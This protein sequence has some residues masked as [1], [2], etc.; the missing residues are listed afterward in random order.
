MGELRQELN[1]T[2]LTCAQVCAIAR[3]GASVTVTE[4]G[5][6]RARAAW[7]VV[8]EVAS[9]RSL[10]GRSTGVGANRLVELGN[11]DGTS[12]GLRLLRSHAGGAGPLLDPARSR[13]MIAVRLNQLAAGGSGVD[14]G[15]LDVLA[16]ALNRGLIPPVHRYGAIGTADLTALASTALCLIGERPWKGGTMPPIALGSADALAFISS[17]AATVGEAALACDD[18]RHLLNASMM[19][20][21]LSFLAVDGSLEPYAAA[22]SDSRPH[23]GQRAVAAR[24][25]SLLAVNASTPGRI[26]DPYS[27]RAL[28]QVHGPAVD[29]AES[30]ERVLIIE[31]NAASE[32][33]LVDVAGN[34]VHHN[35]NFHNAYVA[36]ALDAARAALYQTAALSTSRLGTLIEP[37]Y[38]GLRPFLADA[39]EASSGVMILEYVAHSALA[40]M[41]QH[42]VGAATGTAVVSRGVEEHASFSAQAARSTT[43]VFGG[44][45]VVLACELVAAVRALRLRG[46]SPIGGAL[47]D[48]FELADTVLDKSTQDRPLDDD[49]AVATRLLSEFGAL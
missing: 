48:A 22:V 30:L 8:R 4:E 2:G 45:E 34:E 7:H 9:K 40:D 42:A 27:Y 44:Y 14:P 28:P 10:Y 39:A 17:N 20:A 12:H 46:N 21:A 36:L 43:E 33:P 31:M 25:R 1:G 26:Q 19:I 3:D 37:Q 13:A 35:A 47:R 18:L 41:R 5:Q 6:E 11:D 15:L 32:N 16:E 29:A 23:P 24:L 49:I 38:T